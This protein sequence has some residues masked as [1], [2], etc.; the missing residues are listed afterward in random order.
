MFLLNSTSVVAIIGKS[1]S[2]SYCIV[3]H[4]LKVIIILTEGTTLSL[5][6]RLYQII[7]SRTIE[8]ASRWYNKYAFN[9]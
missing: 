5:A 7:D 9:D 6:G 8:F 2:K 3:L 4:K 1:L